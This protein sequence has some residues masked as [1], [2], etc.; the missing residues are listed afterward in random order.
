[1]EYQYFQTIKQLITAFGTMFDSFEIITDHNQKITVPIHYSPKEK[2]ISYFQE[3]TDPRELAFE[4]TYP[5]MGFEMTGLN[6][7]PERKLNS[8]SR[9]EP[10]ISDS[11][12]FMYDRVP[13][14]FQFSL[15]IGTKKFEDSLKIVEQ[16]IPIFTPE[17]NITIKDF[18]DM[19]I[20]TD[21]PFILNA[22]SFAM[23][24]EGSLDEKRKISW[25]LDFTAKAFL[26]S[27]IR[28]Q[29]RIRLSAMNVTWETMD[30]AFNNLIGSETLLQRI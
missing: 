26:Y 3:C 13:Y 15:Y 27:S 10:H 17:F 21:V 19:D 25:Q 5:R 24:Y 6:F 1:M 29:E 18:P 7:A 14:D 16:I 9:L 12:K 28:T 4:T 8:L 30:D 23:D 20:T 11:K 2:F 22:S